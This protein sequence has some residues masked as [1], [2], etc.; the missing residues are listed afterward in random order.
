MQLND[1]NKFEWLGINS[2]CQQ[3]RKFHAGKLELILVEGR[4]KNLT[5]NGQVQISEIYFALRDPNWGTIPYCLDQFSFE[6]TDDSFS[7]KFHARHEKD[8]IIFEWDGLITGSADSIV[9]YSFQGKAN[10]DFE[11]NRIGFCVLHPACLSGINCDVEHM[12]GS[13]EKGI[14]PVDI[15]PNPLFFGIKAITHYPDTNA[16]VSVVFDG[17]EF[18]MED[19]RNWTDASF[20]T[21][22]TP[23]R[24]PFPVSVKTGDTFSQTITVRLVS[25]KEAIRLEKQNSTNLYSFE[26]GTHA[27]EPIFS[28]GSCITKPLSDGQIESVKDLGLSH[29]R[30][31]YH[32]DERAEL[33]LPVLFQL[34]KLGICMQ[35]AI[36]FT[37][38]WEKE[39]ESI[40][41]L[42]ARHLEG[43]ECITVFQQ[44]VKVI[45]QEILRRIRDG[46]SSIPIKIGSG[47]DAYFSQI[48]REHLP[49]DYVDF[50]SY[51]N[52]PQVHAFDNESIM[53][54]VEGQIANIKSCGSLYTDL[55]IFISP[56][57]MKLRWNPD[58]TG[59][60]VLQPLQCPFDVDV[61]QMSLFAAA[62]FLK[63]L[64]ACASNDVSSITY[65]ELN[66][67]KGIIED[68]KIEDDYYF[69]SVSG[70]HYPL[71]FAF[72][73]L[74]GWEKAKVTTLWRNNL[75]AI[76]LRFRESQRVVLSNPL[77]QENTVS[78]SGFSKSIKYMFI[79]E[80]NIAE[81]AIYP[82]KVWK[83]EFWK[84][85][86]GKQ[87]IILKPYSLC[88]IEM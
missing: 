60:T 66:G 32:F 21:Y 8:N 2:Q 28:L 80:S 71:Y 56:V 7:V 9:S 43:I 34:H 10:S 42:L 78:L 54:T 20:K 46:L 57:S 76:A 14:F 85:E 86:N 87:A 15:S 65:F 1:I 45:P 36:S 11:K 24:L 61:R 73:A 62:W 68:E 33:F 12:D 6:E 64:A 49:S 26:D 30:F 17:D 47:T 39:L 88:I 29:L 38:N 82:E 70:M 58:A 53:S 50:I 27:H 16:A 44:D 23:L 31:D 51:S 72:W 84:T 35:L 59:K 4:L 55:P 67:R 69:P 41:E 83:D 63:S 25:K 77:A 81:A 74:R 18:E 13:V 19:Q 48:N 52:N 3:E 75:T 37:E 40:K 5:F 22:C 79:D